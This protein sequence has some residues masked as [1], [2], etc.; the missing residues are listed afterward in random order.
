MST[1]LKST[2]DFA[3]E[4]QAKLSALQAE[5]KKLKLKLDN[6]EK[7][8][9]DAVSRIDNFVDE[10]YNDNKDMVDIGEVQI[11]GKYKVDL[12]PDELEKRLYAKMLKIVYAFLARG[13]I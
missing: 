10:W 11:C 8:K 6:L 7:T 3:L 12:I 13:M 1:Q 4:M 5:N 9:A 2:C